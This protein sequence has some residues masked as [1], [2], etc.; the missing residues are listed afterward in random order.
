MVHII[1]SEELKNTN[2]SHFPKHKEN[3]P[4]FNSDKE[5]YTLYP[6]GN[7]ISELEY[8]INSISNS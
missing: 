5:Y 4:F 1:K 7:Y 6:K 8:I 3:Y 2:I